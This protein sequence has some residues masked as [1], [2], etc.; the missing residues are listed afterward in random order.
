MVRTVRGP[1]LLEA[2]PGRRESTTHGVRRRRRH[3]EPDLGV[4][5]LLS[6]HLPAALAMPY[7]I[8]SA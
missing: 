2:G 6:G 3:E 4:L 8:T 5:V 7:M 1:K